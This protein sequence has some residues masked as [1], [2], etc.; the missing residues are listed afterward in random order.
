MCIKDKEFYLIS[1]FQFLILY[2]YKD[3]KKQKKQ[4]NTEKK[5]YLIAA[6]FCDHFFTSQRMRIVAITTL[7]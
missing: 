1:F 7:T 6:N 4:N 5:I 3:K 2:V